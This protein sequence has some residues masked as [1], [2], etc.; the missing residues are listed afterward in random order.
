[1]K[2]DSTFFRSRLAR[3]VFLLFI[4]CAALPITVLFIQSFSE[5]TSQLHQQSYRRL[6]QLSKAVGMSSYERLLLLESQMKMIAHGWEQATSTGGKTK[7]LNSEGFKVWFNSMCIFS[8]KGEK[9]VLFGKMSTLPAI[10]SQQRRDLES[11]GTVLVAR[12]GQNATSQLFMLKQMTDKGAK[13]PLLVGEINNGYLWGIGA[14][15]TLP[16][17]TELVVLDDAGNLIISSLPAKTAK[18]ARV[19]YGEN[20][21]ASRQFQWKTGNKNYLACFWTL[22]LKSQFDTSNWTVVVS[23]SSAQVLAPMASFKETYPLVTVLCLLAVLLL[24]M[25]Y[26][27]RTLEPIKTLK[28]GTLH[29]AKGD[30][31]HQVQVAS[32]DELEELAVSFNSMSGQLERQFQTLTTIA[33]LDRTILSSMKS[34]TIVEVML[35][36][37]RNLFL[38]DSALICLFNGEAPGKASIFVQDRHSTATDSGKTFEISPAD[39][40]RLR[41]NPRWLRVDM[42]REPLEYLTACAGNGERSFLVLPV[43]LKDELLAVLNMGYAH[44]DQSTEERVSDARQLADQMAIGLSN[45]KLLKDLEQMNWG[46]LQALARTVDAK[47]PWTAGHSERV[48]THALA[49]AELLHLPPKEVDMLHRAALLHDIGKIGTPHNILDKPARLTDEEYQIIQDHPTIGARILEPIGAYRDIVPII[50]QHHE[51]YDGKGYPLGLAGKDIL[52]AARILAVADVFDALI[53]E[54]P[55]RAG[56]DLNRVIEHMAGQAGLQFDPEI[57]EVFLKN[58]E[59]KET[60]NFIEVHAYPYHVA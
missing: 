51:R 52:L 56:W 49:I 20:N 45:S 60:K 42:E 1:M 24:S 27:R 21:S 29:I 43:L 12:T 28:E 13:A 37:M 39:I 57:V 33:E 6:E 58:M 2:Y 9:T 23:R 35:G 46:A 15:N 31:K 38:C 41:D 48:T 40:G 55:Y 11:G 22:F 18:I 7:H 5:L 16:P 26:I 34:L 50:V 36:S 32:G 53:S 25:V 19:A 10:S 3:R 14:N 44:M 54:R 47:S 30:F 59:R 17:M 8:A 4:C